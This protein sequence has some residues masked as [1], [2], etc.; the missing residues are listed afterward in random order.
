MCDSNKNGPRC[1]RAWSP[2]V[3]THFVMRLVF[4]L[5]STLFKF[6]QILPLYHGQKWA[7]GISSMIYAAKSLISMKCVSTHKWNMHTIH[8][9]I[10]I[11]SAYRT[12]ERFFF[13][14]VGNLHTNTNK[15]TNKQKMIGL[16]STVLQGR[17][18]DDGLVAA[19]IHQMGYGVTW[20]PNITLCER[21][22]TSR[23]I[24][25]HLGPEIEFVFFFGYRPFLV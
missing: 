3:S 1:N 14:S 6:A 16:I 15:Q 2:F 7:A 22:S 21:M 19:W 17:W 5:L 20:N 10:T 12:G 18:A 8:R 25:I 4:V 13:I 11:W 9:F 24:R 23:Q